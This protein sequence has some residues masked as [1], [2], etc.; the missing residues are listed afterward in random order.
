MSKMKRESTNIGVMSEDTTLAEVKE[1]IPSMFPN[2]DAILGGGWPVGRASEVFGAE[3]A[4]KSA[5]SHMAVKGVQ[6]IGGTAMFIDFEASLDPCKM[7]Q[8]GIDESRL[9]YATPEDIE[10]AWDMVWEV[11]AFLKSK[12]PKA[13][14]LIVWDSIAASVPRA[15]LNAES[16]SAAHVGLVARSMSQGCR[17]MYRAIAKVRAHMMWINQERQKIGAAK[18]QQQSDTTGGNAVKYAASIRARCSRVAT[19]KQTV[20]G[21]ERAT[22]Y[23]IRVL[24]RKNKLHPPHQRSSYVLDFTHGPSPE[25]TILDALIHAKVVKS[26]GGGYYKGPWTEDKFRKAE[27]LALMEGSYFRKGATDALLGNLGDSEASAEDV[28]DAGESEDSED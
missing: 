10:E 22:G 27:W 26:A 7:D 14:M 3:G 11:V 2:I 13:P 20:G 25:L 4:G 5:L 17:R 15:E 9:I 19:L 28:D 12:P 8:L 16:S 21:S 24:T 23:A 1:W 6:S 18:F